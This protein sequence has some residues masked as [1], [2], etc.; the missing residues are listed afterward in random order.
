M[1]DIRQTGR[2]TRMLE[3]ARR[4]ANEG[5]AVYV[6]FDTVDQ[7]FCSITENDRRLGIK[8][9]TPETLGNFDFDTLRPKGAWPNCVVLVDHW[10]IEK[11]FAPLLEML[12]RYDPA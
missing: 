2:T 8:G 5:A 7:A 11:R 1:K 10:V 6:V 9:E 3:D 4:L 12:H